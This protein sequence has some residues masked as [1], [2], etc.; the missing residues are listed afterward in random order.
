MLEEQHN[1]DGG[2]VCGGKFVGAIERAVGAASTP[3][4]QDTDSLSV[5]CVQLFCLLALVHAR[6]IHVCARICM[7][8]AKRKLPPTLSLLL[9]LF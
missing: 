3:H 1:I 7:R 4:S 2:A 9:V 5:A 8:D 6:A